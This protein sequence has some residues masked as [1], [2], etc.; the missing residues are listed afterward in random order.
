MLSLRAHHLKENLLKTK[1]DLRAHK[2]ACRH[3]AYRIGQPYITP[4]IIL[5]SAW[6]PSSG[7]SI[8]LASVTV[9]KEQLTGSHRRGCLLQALQPGCMS[10]ATGGVV[11][12]CWSNYRASNCPP[13]Q[14]SQFMV[15]SADTDAQ[16]SI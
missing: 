14:L 6:K 8:V 9:V 10:T 2:A 11:A 1:T 16:H 4:Q 5:L 13:L 7:T 3:Q 15:C 12:A